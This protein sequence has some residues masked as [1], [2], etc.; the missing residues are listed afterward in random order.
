[1]VLIGVVIVII[2]FMLKKNTLVVVTIAGIVTAL[3]ADMTLGEILV[4]FGTAFESSRSL[5]VFV[6]MLPVI[7]LMERHGLREQAESMVKN[8]KSATSGRILNVYLFIRQA[9]AALGLTSLGGHPQMVRPIVAPMAEGAL[10]KKYGKDI[11]EDVRETVKAHSAAADNVG[12]F[13]GEDVFVAFGALMLM[14]TFFTEN[15]IESDPLQMAKWAIPTAIAAFVVHSIRLNMMD[16]SI[17]KRMKEYQ[18]T[19]SKKKDEVK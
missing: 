1:M 11:P 18:G 17:D 8:I 5:A 9:G 13:F 7:G 16:R 15:G 6:A 12:L 4:L 19:H 3:V 10:E 14:N 2:G